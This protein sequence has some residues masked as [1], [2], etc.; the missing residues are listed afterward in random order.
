MSKADAFFVDCGITYNSTATSTI[1]GL[2]HLEGE[3]VQVLADGKVHPDC[4]VTSGAITLN[5]TASKVHV[6]YGFT[7]TLKPMKPDIEGTGIS[8]IKHI[9]GAII[10]FYNT[11]GAKFGTSTSSMDTVTFRT[12][13]DEMNDSPELFTGAKEVPVGGGFEYE[14]DFIIQQT[15]PLPTT[16]RG[17]ILKIGVNQ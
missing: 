13:A 3:T 16:V 17:L 10:S 11:L 2:S 6:G 7:S 15:Q 8:V 5:Y 1:T 4:V 12:T 14:G 9:F